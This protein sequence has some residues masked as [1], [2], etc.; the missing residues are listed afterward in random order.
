M[1]PL[2][3]DQPYYYSRTASDRHKQRPS[4]TTNHLQAMPRQSRE[5]YQSDSDSPV[6]LGSNYESGL[7]FD[8]DLI[9]D[10]ED[11]D[12]ELQGPKPRKNDKAAQLAS[13]LMKDLAVDDSI[14]FLDDDADY[15][16]LP[17]DMDMDEDD[18]DDLLNNLRNAAH[19]KRKRP[20]SASS[21]KRQVMNN[22][23]LDP[24]KR[25]YM[26][27]GNAAF[28]RG[29]LETA[30]K[31]YVEVIKID[32]KSYN[33]YKTLAEICQMQ[34]KY[35]K[36]CKFMLMAALSNPSDVA[37]WGQAAELST[38]LGHIDQAIYCYTRAIA[39]KNTE[40]DY[41]FII[42]R[43]GLYKQKR[44]YGRALEG[45]Q[46]L[47]QQ[48]PEDSS[49]VKQL[50]DVYV[51]QKRYNDAIALYNRILEKN[52]NPTETKVPRFNWSE[53]N[54]LTELYISKRSWT[55]A[56]NIIKI[57][58]RWIQK[59]TDETWWDEQQDC[60]AEFDERRG[61]AIMKKKPKFYNECAGRP[62]DLP[63]DIR[64]KLGFL[65]LELDQKEEALRHYAFLFLEEDKWEVSDLFYEAGKHL[66]SKGFYE[67]AI[68]YLKGVIDEE[69]LAEVQYLLGKCYAE[70]KEYETAKA[71]LLE[72]MKDDPDNDY[73]KT[74][75]IEVLYYT[76]DHDDQA[77]ASR[78]IRE[79]KAP[80]ADEA[81]P[82][83]TDYVP[84]ADDD[85][86]QDN[87]AL[88]KNARE[89]KDT[90]KET[91]TEEEREEIEQR[92]TRMVLDKFNRMKRL[93]EAIDQGHKA[94][95]SAWMNIASQ[96]IDM[97]TSVKAFFPKNRKSTFRGIV[98]YLR[99][100]Q[101][102]DINN[103]L[104]RINNLYEGITETTNSRVTLTA[105][106]E[107]RGL[108][109]DQW[110]YIF[111]QNALL[112]RLFDHNLDEAI[113]ILEV[114]FDVNV[115]I[116]DKQRVMILRF[117]RLSLAIDQ[118]DYIPTVCNNVRYVLTSTQFSPTVYGIFMCCFASGVAAW[119]AFSNYNHQ[120]YFLRQLKAYDSLLYSSKVSGA[121]H[122]TVDVKGMSFD[123]EL[124]LL[125][126][127]Y[128]C[129]LGSNRAYSSPI[130]YLTR[131]YKK[132]YN[133]PTICLMLGL[134]HVH[135]SMQR[136]SSNR[137]MQ[138]LQ[139]ISFLLEYRDRRSKN[140]TDY[141][142]QEIEYN[143][144]RLFHMLGLPA[145]AINHYN[146]V[147]E[148]HETLKDNPDYDLL[149]DAAYNL[150]LIYTI[151]G[152]TAMTEELTDKYLTI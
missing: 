86:D 102:L 42:R 108:S 94:A 134:A 97:F 41:D 19:M 37:L 4:P 21:F 152:N 151:N 96:L 17:E 67:D 114:A 85:D 93:Q 20:K 47:S 81:Q 27:R 74:I 122:V 98:M 90:K 82:E 77:L 109:Y 117:V 72:A 12:P 146:K 84:P 38:D 45:L 79:L 36:C 92:A 89:Y 105:Q 118:Q 128:A 129:L 144:G 44:Q 53:L 112:V 56:I 6:S 138:L 125:L 65:R 63:I 100:K 121:A 139:G 101:D 142:K 91:L 135:R 30:W 59:R 124:P 69:H 7:D 43:S 141:E 10:D 147:L 78:L 113:S 49:V 60:D 25:T 57:V 1:T 62:H 14:D 137:H 75:L 18:D 13:T 71:H 131:A 68:T 76:N 39:S 148:Y 11:I 9:S 2:L 52:M 119:A 126:Y 70:I 88:I 140:S 133:D 32:N 5:T 127:M 73:L 51:H 29:D 40:H 107:F 123:K 106:T 8:E 103:R 35:N 143:F 15:V 58:A 55:S 54:I 99:R 120:K 22:K 136:N 26:S 66:E 3:L 64:F 95:A 80:K 34:N 48:Y 150:T 23:D 111:V 46:R 110:L 61:P 132:C 149:I 145:L 115:F 104:A 83:S 130:V 116:Q 50:A 31:N 28:V 87:I 24:E 16:A 33:A